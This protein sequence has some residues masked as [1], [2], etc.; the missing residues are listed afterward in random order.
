MI[1]KA[2]TDKTG[3]YLGTI[4]LEKHNANDIFVKDMKMS[5]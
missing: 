5:G 1:Q 2:E 3:N 4:W